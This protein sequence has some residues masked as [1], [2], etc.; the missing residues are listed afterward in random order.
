MVAANGSSVEEVAQRQLGLSTRVVLRRRLAALKAYLE[1]GER[2]VSVALAGP[3]AGI[4]EL[5]PGTAV[6]VLIVVLLILLGEDG[7]GWL[8]GALG[9]SLV[10]D[11]LVRRRRGKRIFPN[12]LV[13]VTDRR[14]LYLEGPNL[15][16]GLP[17]DEIRSVE[18]QRRGLGTATL[19]IAA[20][21]RHAEFSITSD[22]PKRSA[23]KAADDI[24]ESLNER[25]TGLR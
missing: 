17:R 16:L 14:F 6:F 18:R 22:W 24:V 2:P 5:I 10:V 15:S 11:L 25:P 1:E 9:A 7:T 4:R 23:R 12:G 3:M 8:V 19:R 21:G 20:Q 13:A